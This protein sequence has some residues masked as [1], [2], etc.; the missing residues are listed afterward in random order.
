MTT[1][2]AWRVEQAEAQRKAAVVKEMVPPVPRSTRSMPSQEIRSRRAGVSHQNLRALAAQATLARRC[3]YFEPQVRRIASRVLSASRRARVPRLSRSRQAAA[4]R[5]ALHSCRDRG[6]KVWR[7]VRLSIF[8][9][10]MRPL[11]RRRRG[12]PTAEARIMSSLHLKQVMIIILS[13][14][15][16]HPP[17]FHAAASTS[18]CLTQYDLRQSLQTRARRTTCLK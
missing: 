18:R 4:E 15:A 3:C 9:S 12:R 2:P 6:S 14:L 13:L 17:R 5:A 11:R 10:M 16:H 7:A 1:R 8:K